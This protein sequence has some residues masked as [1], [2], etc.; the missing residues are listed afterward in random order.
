MASEGAGASP[1]AAAAESSGCAIS[2][3][4]WDLDGTLIDTESLS[5][6][7][8]NLALAPFGVVCEPPLKREIVGTRRDWW[9]SHLVAR[10]GLE[11]KL[12]PKALGE[13]WE[14]RCAELM[15]SAAAMPGVESVTAA[16]AA[17]GVPQGIATSSTRPQ[18]KLAPHPKVAA[19]MGVIVTGDMVARS[20]PA[21]DIFLEA[22]RR[23]GTPP[24][25]CIVFEDSP[26][27]VRG[28]R[29]AGMVAVAVPDPNVGIPREEFERAGAHL[30]LPSLE[31]CDVDMLLAMTPD[32]PAEAGG[33]G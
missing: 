5:T 2:A 19:R 28:A 10:L 30:I 14:E 27:G 21:P 20:K 9:T 33:S 12:E 31:G 6:T 1:P 24:G 26:L 3:C 8:I 23:M 13:M 18:L 17:R 16:L 32:A 22:A 15:P 7:A 25:R 4:I 11:G 29:D